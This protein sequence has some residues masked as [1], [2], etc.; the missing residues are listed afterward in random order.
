MASLPQI[1]TALVSTI[2]AAVAGIQGYDR[3]PES[4][5][6]PAFMVVPR[7]SDFGKSMGRGFDGYS[8]DVIVLVSSADDQLAQSALDPYVNG[9]GSSSIRQ[10][11]FNGRTLGID[12]DATV[13]GMSDYGAQYNVG[14]LDYVGAKLS[15]DVLTSGTA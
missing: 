15:V 7:S 6:L 5:N 4:V 12:V 8:F 9:F 10:A 2:S 13:T 14:G 3:V 11:V 1:R